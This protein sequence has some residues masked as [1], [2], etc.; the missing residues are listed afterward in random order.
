[1]NSNNLNDDFHAGRYLQ[2]SLMRSGFSIKWLAEK[3]NIDEARLERYF[4][5][6]YIDAELFVDIG[7]YLGDAFFDSLKVTMFGRKPGKN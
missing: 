1:M 6:P 2:E 5:L 7:R 4:T 3:T